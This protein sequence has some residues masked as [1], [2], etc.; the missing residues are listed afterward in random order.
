MAAYDQFLAGK[1]TDVE[2]EPVAAETAEAV[3]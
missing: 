2:Y 1:L 3:A